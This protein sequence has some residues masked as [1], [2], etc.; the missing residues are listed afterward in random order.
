M[1]STTSSST[2]ST[3]STS[4]GG[5]LR[6]SGLSSGLDTD[7]IIQKLL[8]ADQQQITDLQTKEE[9]NKAEIDTW[10][11]V[12]AQLKSF[13]AIVTKLRSDGTTGNTLFDDKSVT[14]T[15]ATVATGTASSQAIKAA[16][17][18]NVTTMARSYVVY[19]TQKTSTYTLPSA[20]TVTLNGTSISLATGDNLIAIANK[21]SNA[22]YTTGN[23]LTATVI[24]NRLVVQ[25]KNTGAAS[26][27]FGATSG[28]PPFNNA[29]D[30]PANILQTEL[31]VIDSSG[32]FVN[33]AQTSIDAAFSI[34]G[35]SISRAD[36]TI[37][38]VITGVTLNLLNTG[39][40]T[41]QIAYNTTAIRQT[42]S[43]FVDS[44]NETRDLIDRT[45]NAKLNDSDQFGLLFSDSL[46]RDLYN[47][48]RSL[49]TTGVTMGGAGW[50]GTPQLSVAGTAGD[51]QLTLNGF[52]NATGTLY[53]GDS[54]LLSGSSQVYTLVG[55]ATISGNT[56]TV[57]IHPPLTANSAINTT[58]SLATKTLEECGV[59]VTTDSDSGVGGVLGI[60]DAGK[61]DSLLANN[62]PL[63]KEIFARTGASSGSQGVA[64]RLY[65]WI[66]A[67]TKISS[68]SSTKR[69]IDDVKIPGIED[70]DTRIEDQ[71]AR[72]QARLKKKQDSLVKQFSDM[73]TAIA[74]AQ[75]ASSAVANLS[76]NASS[77]SA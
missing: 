28:T 4:G 56:A 40:S 30:D 50:A 45:R 54:F 1:T 36:N 71:I 75:S 63:V 2:G 3:S 27:I 44:Y 41:V 24:D 7:S 39:S 42:I 11:T 12:A 31:G 43:D 18:V 52:T 74:N 15:N 25:T 58:I 38:D 69:A 77:S 22:S 20:G 26:T 34:N 62:V 9:V 46:L 53:A 33:V 10:N 57:N 66:D 73:E 70:E 60:L 35:M 29:T 5:A 47:N 67:Q 17:N 72:L 68:F 49:T 8:A 21:I 6:L 23:E 55:D 65:A 48:V 51:K 14:S 61:L 37:D 64:R 16:Y 32:G 59:G 19:G 76:L 13:A